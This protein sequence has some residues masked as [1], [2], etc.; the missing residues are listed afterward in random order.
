VDGRLEED[1]R[2]AAIEGG[3]RGEGFWASL[4]A[5][6]ELA[7][8]ADFLMRDA[9][10]GVAARGQRWMAHAWREIGEGEVV[11]TAIAADARFLPAVLAYVPFHLAGRELAEVPRMRD[12]VDR[13]LTGAVLRPIEWTFVVPA[14]E[15][16]GLGGAATAAQRALAKEHSVIGKR[17]GA[18][19][20]RDDAY[21]LVH[22][23]YYA[24][25]WGHEVPSYSDVGAEGYVGAILPALVARAC[26]DEDADLLAEL[27]LAS[28]T[29]LQHA[30]A[31]EAYEIVER[32]QTAAG[33]LEGRGAVEADPAEAAGSAGLAAP[34]APAA[35]AALERSSGPPIREARFQRLGHPTMSRTYHTTLA[36]IM[37]WVS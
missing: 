32:A 15:L 24:A 30:V 10:A 12:V 37:A 11:R 34:A 22:E 5:V 25:R 20:V 36:A 13:Q 27:I 3:Q 9:R 16:L 19:M 29:T 35:P 4:K 33:N 14:L 31:P 23:C 6:A 7:H 26:A 18:D 21:I 28:R 17:P 8:A 1:F 2:L